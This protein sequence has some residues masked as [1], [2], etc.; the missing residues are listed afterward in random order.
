MYIS[1]S[2]YA[3]ARSNY[4]V[5]ELCFATAVHFIKQVYIARQLLR[6]VLH[7]ILQLL[8][9]RIAQS[10]GEPPTINGRSMVG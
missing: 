3:F 5:Q 10:F 8:G 9:L 2:F 6:C 4:I 1:V 7:L